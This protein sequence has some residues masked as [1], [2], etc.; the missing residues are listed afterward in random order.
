[1]QEKKKIIYKIRDYNKILEYISTKSEVMYDKIKEET[2]FEYMLIIKNI[3][4]SDLITSGKRNGKQPLAN[5]YLCYL[6]TKEM[7][8]IEKSRGF[9]FESTKQ[10][11]IGIPKDFFKFFDIKKLERRE[12][13]Q[14]EEHKHIH[15]NEYV[16]IFLVNDTLE[17]FNKKYT[18]EVFSKLDK[19][20]GK[21]YFK[22]YEMNL[23]KGNFTS[24]KLTHAI[25]GI[26]TQEDK[27]FHTLRKT[28]FKND[29]IIFLLRKNE[30]TKELYILLEK[31]P[32]FYTIIGQTNKIWEKYLSNKYEKEKNKLNIK[33][34]LLNEESEKSRKNQNNW[35]NLLAK[36]MLNYSNDDEIFCPLTYIKIKFNE[37]GTLFRAS[38]IK[39]FS[40]CT[41]EEA[42]DINNGILMV[43]NADALFDKH[44][45]TLDNEGNL[46]F[47]FLIK[48]N[49]KLRQ[50][51]KLT[52]NFFKP[53]IK[54]RIKYLECHRKVFEEK[55]KKRKN[56]I[57]IDDIDNIY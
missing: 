44:L 48:D 10:S 21:R 52:D 31:N 1:M 56:P 54:D 12:G 15:L 7:E 55:E 43:A 36:E 38:H 28:I 37:V 8:E 29:T 22:D 16:K 49:F 5:N 2:E 18:E 26:G 23:E 39:A 17:Y 40:D 50:D 53:I 32:I 6:S 45:I 30:N 33:D 42:Y 51:L 19:D 34:N 13:K 20:V 46:I 57:D 11:N 41:L 27:T 3:T 35:R 4:H 47:S 24:I 25:H 9:K 14:K